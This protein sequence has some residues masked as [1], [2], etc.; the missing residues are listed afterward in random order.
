MTTGAA[1]AKETPGAAMTTEAAMMAHETPGAAMTTGA[2]MAKS[3]ALL[4]GDFNNKGAEP[5]AGKAI[6]GKTADGKIV[7]R[8]ENLKSAN[9]PDL[10]VYL[11]KE[12][13]PASDTQIKSGLEV[14]KLKATEGNLNYELDSK[15]DISQYK[16]VAIYCKSFS[17]IFGYANIATQP[18]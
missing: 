14:G 13:S 17:T 8:F 10:Y 11:T 18:A 3:D 4:A 5:V 1:M 16:A 12:G 2:A 6:L 15:L 7:L 9:G